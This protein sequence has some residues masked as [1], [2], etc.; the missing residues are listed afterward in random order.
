MILGYLEAGARDSDWVSVVDRIVAIGKL[1][2]QVCQIYPLLR[3]AIWCRR[4]RRGAKQEVS[5]IR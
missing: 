4:R 1:G 3:R 2:E 5:I